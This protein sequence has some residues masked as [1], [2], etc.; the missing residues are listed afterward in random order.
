ML[1]LTT[2]TLP[3]GVEL[4]YRTCGKLF[5]LCCLQAKTKVTRTSVNEL[6]YT[7][8]ACVC[9]VSED[10]L[11]TL[12]NTFMDAYKSMGP[13]LNIHKMKVIH[14]PGLALWSKPPITKV[15][16]E[17]LQNVDH[18]QYLRRI[19]SAKAAIDE[20]IQHRLSA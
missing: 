9:A 7:G 2:N 10:V 3:T 13:T 17:A 8:D 6:Q 11:Q 15:H 16:R 12:I 18:F 19:L 5:N 4:T 14:Q 20:E 1:H